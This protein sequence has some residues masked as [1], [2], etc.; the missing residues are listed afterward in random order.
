MTDVIEPRDIQRALDQWR[1][2]SEKEPRCVYVSERAYDQLPLPFNSLDA[3]DV[4]VYPDR[5][6]RD[7]VCEVDAAP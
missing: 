3:L 2:H 6:L 4:L 5:E 1:E 7:D